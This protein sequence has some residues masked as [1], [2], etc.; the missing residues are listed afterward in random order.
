MK[1]GLIILG[2]L[3]VVSTSCKK[4][5]TC[6]CTSSGQVV[7]TSTIKDTKGKAETA[8]NGN[9]VTFLGFTIDCSI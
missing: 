1:K 2:L 6:T 9:D 8:C 3:I 7:S 4:E 5:Y